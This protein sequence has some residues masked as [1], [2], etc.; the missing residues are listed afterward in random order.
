MQHCYAQSHV[1]S[2][3]RR[4]WDVF[5]RRRDLDPA[6]ASFEEDESQDPTSAAILVSY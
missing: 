3:N 5:C 1:W 2:L 4:I 6:P